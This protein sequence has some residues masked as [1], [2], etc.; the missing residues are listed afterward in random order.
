[1]IYRQSDLLKSRLDDMM[2]YATLE[3]QLAENMAEGDLLEE[4]ADG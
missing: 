2:A 3:E 1:M 4:L